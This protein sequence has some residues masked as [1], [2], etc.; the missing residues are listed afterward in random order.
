MSSRASPGI[1]G[2]FAVVA[3]CGQANRFWLGVGRRRK[4][5]SRFAAC[6]DDGPRSALKNDNPKPA[7]SKY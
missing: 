7:I 4:S 6:L 3:N 1:Q 5:R 2:W